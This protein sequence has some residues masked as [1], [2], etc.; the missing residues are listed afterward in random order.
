MFLV[1]FGPSGSGDLASLSR[2]NRKN[3]G[4]NLANLEPRLSREQEETERKFREI[5]NRNGHI[6]INGR[7]SVDLIV[8]FTFVHMLSAYFE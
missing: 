4:L 7:V 3:L 8:L 2:P 6:N 1:N 5:D